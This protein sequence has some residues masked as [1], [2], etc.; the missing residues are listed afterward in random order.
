VIELYL[1]VSNMSDSSEDPFYE[2]GRKAGDG[3]K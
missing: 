2:D 1:K 3:K